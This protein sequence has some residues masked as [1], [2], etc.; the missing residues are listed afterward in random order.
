MFTKFIARFVFVFSIIF[1][2]NIAQAGAIL[3]KTYDANTEDNKA[4]IVFNKDA[5]AYA[6]KKN[7]KVNVRLNTGSFIFSCENQ[8]STNILFEEINETLMTDLNKKVIDVS[9]E[10]SIY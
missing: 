7:K 6:T 8:N 3:I 9:T 2:A 4:L 1:T 5:I 10:C